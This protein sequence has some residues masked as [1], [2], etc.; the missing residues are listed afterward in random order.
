MIDL[1]SVPIGLTS[2]APKYISS[3]HQS[4]LWFR[5]V[6]LND[7]ASTEH[8]SLAKVPK[9]DLRFSRLDPGLFGISN[10]RQGREER[11]L[12]D[13]PSRRPEGWLALLASLIGPDDPEVWPPV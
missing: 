3:V 2:H 7:L 5:K 12:P 11:N 8:Q 4:S 9:L 6:Q 13:Y 1:P 10:M